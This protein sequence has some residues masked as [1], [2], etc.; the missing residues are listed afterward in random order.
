[1]TENPPGRPTKGG[2]KVPA[3]PTPP[4]FG[5]WRPFPEPAGPLVPSWGAEGQPP[6][7]PGRPPQFQ[8]GLQAWGPGRRD[9]QAAVP[10]GPPHGSRGLPHPAH[11]HALPGCQTPCAQDPT[12]RSISDPAQPLAP[13]LRCV[14]VAT[15]WQL[16]ES[17]AG[18]LVFR[19]DAFPRCADEHPVFPRFDRSAQRR[20]GSATQPSLRHRGPIERSRKTPHGS[21]SARGSHP[22]FAQVER[23]TR[24]KAA[25]S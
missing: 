24:S 5:P 7:P 21:C 13:S 17:P 11:L 20:S 6:G 22:Q 25:R 12:G 19:C 14:G 23:K 9:P 15:A 3:A 18:R 2:W 4:S 1:M 16:P 10:L 8:N